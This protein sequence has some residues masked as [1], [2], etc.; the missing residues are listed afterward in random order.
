MSHTSQIIAGLLV[1]FALGSIPFGYLLVR[2]V[3][4]KD[5]RTIGSGNI[6]ATNVGRTL[7]PIG[8]VLTLFLDFSKG[9]GGVLAAGYVSWGA[10][11]AALG[12]VLG[13][14]FTP[15]LGGRGGKGVATL[16][17][18]FSVVAP[19]PTAVA[20]VILALVAAISRMMSL[21]SLCGTVALAAGTWW[22]GEPRATI[23]AAAAAAIV[24]IWQ[25]RGNIQRIVAGEEPKLGGPDR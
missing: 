13:H 6:G 22:W 12:A 11:E 25:H 16:L 8:G 1:G 5:V 15:W 17:G 21:G 20:A 4:G 23:S 19:L 3:R 9:A 7:G 10:A 18:G 14:C 2:L 24:I